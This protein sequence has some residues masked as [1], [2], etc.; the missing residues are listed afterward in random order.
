VFDTSV[1]SKGTDKESSS[2]SAS[3]TDTKPQMKNSEK[4]DRVFYP[5]PPAETEYE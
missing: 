1:V 4:Q 3:V 2:S 5:S